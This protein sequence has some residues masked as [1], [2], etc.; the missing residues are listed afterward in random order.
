[1][2]EH[3]PGYDELKWSGLL[4]QI[5]RFVVKFDQVLVLMVGKTCFQSI[6]IQRNKFWWKSEMKSPSEIIEI[7]EMETQESHF[8][9]LDHQD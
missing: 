5:F 8:I 4:E 2:Q 3:G 6:N 1:M 7:I 9:H